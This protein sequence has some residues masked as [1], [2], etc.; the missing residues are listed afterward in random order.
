MQERQ[1]KALIE[2]GIVS[3]E[4]IRDALASDAGRKGRLLAA[5][6]DMNDIDHDKLLRFLSRV[7][8]VPFLDLDRVKPDEKLL[9]ECSENLCV[10]YN[11]LPIDRVND[12]EWIIAIDNPHDY[13]RLDSIT[14][15]TG[16]RLKT[17]FARPD[18]IQRKVRELYQGDA[19][20]DATMDELE[21]SG[22]LSGGDFEVEKQGQEAANLDELKRG[23]EDS[24]IIKLVN[25]IIIKAM[26]IGSSDIHIEPGER[27]SVVRL[28][29]DGR[30]RPVL[31]FPV[32]AHPL[33][34]SR[35]K[36]MAK[37]DISNMRTPQDGRTRVRMWGKNYDLRVSTLPAMHGEK[38]VLRILDKS[39]LAL[40]LDKLGFE[41]LAAKRV[42]RAIAMPTG[43]VLVTGPTGSGK[44]TTL[45]SFINHIHDEEINIITVEDPVEFQ[46]KGINQVQV[47]PKAGMTF[48]AALR[49]ILRQDP[50]VVLV[51]EI[52]DEETAEIALHAAQTGHL[53]LSTLHTNDAP[54]TLHRLHEMGLDPAL[55]AASVNLIVA[56]RLVRRLCPNCK[57]PDEVKEEWREQFDIPER[58]R[59]FRAVG[60]EK[61]ANTGYRGRIAIH[62]VLPVTDNMREM[63]AGQASVRELAEAARRE[64]MLCLFEDGLAKAL[65]GLT[66]LREVLRSSVPPEGFSLAD[67]LDEEGR[68]L[69][70]GAASSRRARSQASSA[71][72]GERTVLIVDDSPSVR[73][74]VSFVLNAEKYKVV[75]AEDGMRAWQMLQEM[76]PD[77][78]ISDYEMPNMTGPELVQ[79]MRSSR[80]FDDVPAMLLTSRKDEEDEVMGLEIGADDYIFK[81]IEPLKLQARVKKILAMY[82]RIRNAARQGA[83]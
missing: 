40:D 79:R 14:F 66:T 83:Q 60:C 52:R 76:K 55:I 18:Q 49:S 80:R 57:Q 46:L 17:V 11:F 42:R 28:R 82:D 26:K 78:V 67:Q 50:D 4:Q 15:K 63:I 68:L 44:T 32:K 56:Q 25:G 24:P 58:A 65:R 81:P 72:D 61:C 35:I 73:N 10:E 12:R 62:E 9:S 48:A 27:Q 74:L 6:L 53:V 29:I 22:D 7:Y 8:K 23:A 5:L 31:H 21:Q 59:F 75:Q 43:A 69:G 64:N 47:N 1:Q 70:L 37:L 41:E 36:I 19:A 34:A 38:V 3:E 51:G 77:L 33:V 71:G 20:F 30:L 2:S 39:A 13:Q 54:S 45:Y 16:K